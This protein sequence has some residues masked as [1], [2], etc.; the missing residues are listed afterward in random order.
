[1][2]FSDGE[3]KEPLNTYDPVLISLMPFAHVFCSPCD[4]LVLARSRAPA[5]DAPIIG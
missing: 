3:S 4:L 5:H 1:M 2:A